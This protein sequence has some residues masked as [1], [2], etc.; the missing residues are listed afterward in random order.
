ML[1]FNSIEMKKLFT[2]ILSFTLT[3]VIAQNK[4]TKKADEL[5]QR[6]AFSDAADAYKKLLKRGKGGRYVFAQLG[7]CY[8]QI[9]DLKNAATYFKRVVKGRR[10]NPEV[11]YTYAQVLNA[12]GKLMEHDFYMNKFAEAKPSINKPNSI[13]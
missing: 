9:N 4:D 1:N 10:V 13:K 6:M 7:N 8:Y 12:S 3:V 5:Y 2:L 11:F